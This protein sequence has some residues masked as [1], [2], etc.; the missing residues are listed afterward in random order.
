MGAVLNTSNNL[1]FL[2]LILRQNVASS[3]SEISGYW[4]LIKTAIAHTILN[5]DPF[6]SPKQ[7]GETVFRG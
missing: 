4:K 7:N 6:W 5:F 2:T 1:W 3:D